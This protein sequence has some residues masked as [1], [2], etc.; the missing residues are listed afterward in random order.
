[1]LLI[2]GK[3]SISKLLCLPLALILWPMVARNYA[4]RTKGRL[5]DE[6]YW[7]DKLMLK[8]GWVVNW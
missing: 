1:M 2:N 8:M 7:A 5:P 6:W 3:V 4:L